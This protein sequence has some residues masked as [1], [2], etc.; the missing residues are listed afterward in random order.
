M[1]QVYRIAM[2]QKEKQQKIKE[3][4]ERREMRKKERDKL[5][6]EVRFNG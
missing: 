3:R 1:C 5:G 2:W 4:K 6:D